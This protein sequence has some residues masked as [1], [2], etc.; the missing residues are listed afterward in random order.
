[1]GEATEQKD[2]Q[3]EIKATAKPEYILVSL[4]L[5]FSHQKWTHEYTS[6]IVIRNKIKEEEEDDEEKM[7]DQEEDEVMNEKHE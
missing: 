7:E 4:L 3:K 1:M 5:L 2:R 6:F